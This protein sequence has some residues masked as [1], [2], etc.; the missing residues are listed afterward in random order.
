MNFFSKAQSS[1]PKPSLRKNSPVPIN[2]VNKFI[3]LVP[4]I[5]SS[6]WKSSSTL[7]FAVNSIFFL[8]LLPWPWRTIDYRPF[9]AIF[10]L[11]PPSSFLDQTNSL[12]FVLFFQK[13]HLLKALGL[14]LF[15]ILLVWWVLFVC[16]LDLFLIRILSSFLLDMWFL[17]QTQNSEFPVRTHQ[18]R[19]SKINYHSHY[20]ILEGDS[21]F[22][23]HV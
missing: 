10:I 16:L 18:S 4:Q 2:V 12:P 23:G 21:S 5:A 6:C 22:E 13:L 15:V 9:S 8:F 20:C 19:I 14:C 17:N 11:C 3:L 1:I 7:I